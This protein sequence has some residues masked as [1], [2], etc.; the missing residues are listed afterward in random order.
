MLF[1][2]FGNKELTKSVANIYITNLAVADTLF[3]VSLPFTS[4]QRVLLSW[5]F[6]SG[7]C[8]V[9]QLFKTKIMMHIF[10]FGGLGV[11]GGVSVFSGEIV[12]G[13]FES[14]GLQQVYDGVV[15]NGIHH[16]RV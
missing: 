8:K 1:V 2:I 9:S 5:P 7:M 3:L 13:F 15:E 12:C 14:K 16:Q 11:G 4:T 10:H 6:G